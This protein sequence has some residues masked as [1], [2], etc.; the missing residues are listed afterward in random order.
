MSPPQRAA[1][2]HTGARSPTVAIIRGQCQK[3]MLIAIVT[4]PIPTERN[5]MPGSVLNALPPI[6]HITLMVL[7]G[8]ILFFM[9]D[10]SHS[11]PI[12]I[13]PL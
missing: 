13:S 9:S 3:I 12:R 8:V 10:K 1:V 7:N 2:L 6:A 4:I 5:F 11:F